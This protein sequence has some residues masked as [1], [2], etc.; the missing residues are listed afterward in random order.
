M[1]RPET[2]SSPLNWDRHETTKVPYRVFIDPDIYDLEQQRIFRGATWSFLALEAEIP[3][4]FDYKS[5]FIGDTPVVVT[6]DAAGLCH[7]WVNRCAHRGALVC[8]DLRGNVREHTCVYHQWAYQPSGELI[9]VP[10]RKGLGGKGGYPADF[11]PGDHGLHRLKVQTFKGLVFGSFDPDMVS[12]E[13][14]LGDT[15]TRWAGRVLDRTIEFLG[16]ARQQIQSNWKLYTENTKDPYH[17]SLLHLFHATFGVYRSSMGGGCDVGGEHGMHS[18]L[19]SF[20]IEN[21][22]LSEY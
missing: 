21:E 22:D 14:Y 10:F 16:T 2:V 6:R 17:A 19:R 8:R 3:E 15:M 1:N 7:A 13:E 11:A 5:T 4:P 9:G 18:L 20:T 12:V